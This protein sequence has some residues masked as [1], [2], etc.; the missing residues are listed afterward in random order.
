VEKFQVILDDEATSDFEMLVTSKRYGQLAYRYLQELYDFPPKAWGDV[1][2]K[3]GL[4]YF[5]SDNHVI[6]DVQGKIISDARGH[7]YG[8]KITRFR[9]RRKS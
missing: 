9:L 5:K 8:V 7:A 1:H 3:E 2:V 4:S 6:F